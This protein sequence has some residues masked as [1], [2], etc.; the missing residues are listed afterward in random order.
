MANERYNRLDNQAPVQTALNNRDL[1]IPRSAF[2]FSAMHSGSALMGALTPVD[3]FDVVPGEDISISLAAFLELRNPT[4]RPL[5]NSCRVFFHAYYN[6]FTDLWEG[7]KNFLDTGRSGEIHLT[8]PNLIYKVLGS[9]SGYAGVYAN[10]NTPLS[11]LHYLGLPCEAVE[12]YKARWS[13][14]SEV[15]YPPLYW[16]RCA[17]GQA[18]AVSSDP[19]N[20]KQ[21]YEVSQNDGFFPADCAFAYQRNWRDYYAPKNLLQNNKYWF[22]DNEDHFILSYSCKNAVCINYENEDLSANVTEAS[23]RNN[24]ILN[25]IGRHIPALENADE[26]LTLT[27]EPNNPV[28]QSSDWSFTQMPNLSGLKFRQ[29]RGDR[30]TTGLPFPDLVRGSIPVLSDFVS[31]DDIL[32]VFSPDERQLL[33]VNVFNAD[34]QVITTGNVKYEINALGVSDPD[35]SGSSSEDDVTLVLSGQNKT[36]SNLTALTM[37]DIRALETFTVFKERMARTSGDY[38][39]M[40]KAQFN[41]SPNVHDRKGTYIGGFYQDFNFSSVMQTSESSTSS[42]LGTKAGQGSSNGSGNIGHFSV[43]D[44]GW[45]QIYMSIVPDVHYTQ[46]KPRMFSKQTQLDMY[47]PIF[48]NLEPQAILN[49]ELFVSGNANVDNDVIAYEDRYAEYKSRQNRVSGLMALPHDVAEYDASRIIARRFTQTPAFN[50]QFVTMLPENL[51][52]SPFSVRDEPPFDF[53]VGISV[54]RVFPGPYTAVPG[55][56]SSKLSA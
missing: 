11:L 27:P 42:P 22:P 52:M 9:H 56:M 55:S 46:G 30:F 24:Q 7:A 53:S 45:I 14:G 54:R 31:S 49:K 51:D 16:F 44:F 36:F 28:T 23:A 43:P 50:N 2:D 26:D 29:F 33:K 8:R 15:E 40:M 34:R 5:L 18:S 17:F 10:A 21:I 35:P 12:R 19:S 37:N 25:L 1:S 4:V 48:N 47:F 32:S 3:C 41:R 38:N 39:E 6:Q 13:Q 20:K